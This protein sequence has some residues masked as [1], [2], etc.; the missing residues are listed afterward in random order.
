MQLLSHSQIDFGKWDRAILSSEYPFVFAQSFYLN[1]TSPGW[2]AL[3]K[4]D[5]ESVMPLTLKKKYGIEY[6]AQPPFTSQLGIYGE[7][8]RQ[9]SERFED[10]ITSRFRFIEIEINANTKFTGIQKRTFMLDLRF[11]YTFNENTRR[12]IAKAKRSGL[13]VKEVSNDKVLTLSAK[14]FHPFLK[15]LK[16]SKTHIKFFDALVESS[17]KQQLIKTL[18]VYKDDEIRA[19]AVFICKGEHALYLKG[20]NLDKNSGSMHLLMEKAIEYYAGK[21]VK[22]FDFGGGQSETLARFYSG[23]GAQPFNY[24]VYKYNNLPFPL[25]LIK[26]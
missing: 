4:G 16:I 11:P 13:K 7:C 1:A 22:F 2:S 6:L 19:L 17:A 5:Y 10:F 15:G 26:K 23:F 12:N 18:S 25:K 3:V 9:I 8:D 24:N 20:V 14:Y 21:H